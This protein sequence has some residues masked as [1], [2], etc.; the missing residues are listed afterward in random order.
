MSH[1]QMS[2]P[3][4]W[5]Q[6]DIENLEGY[7]P[8]G[9]HPTNINDKFLNGRY[10]VVHKLGY[11]SYST[12]WLAR[13]Q[14]AGRYVALKI[15]VAEVSG[16]AVES[17]ILR[18]LQ[19]GNPNHP[20]RQYIASLLNEFFFTGP[21]GHHRCLVS[22][23]HGCS[24]AESKENSTDFKFSPDISRAIAAQVTLGLAYMHS[25]G[26]GHGDL[27]ARNI[28]LRLDDIDCMSTQEIYERFGKPF[29]VS[30]RRMDKAPIGQEAPTH[31]IIPM[32]TIVPSNRVKDCRVKIT[33]FGTSFL[34]SDCKAPTT[35][36]TPTTLLPPEAFFNDPINV[37]ADIWTLGC[38]LYDI[39]GERPLFETW[40]GDPDDV[41]GEM[42]STLGPFPA[43]WWQK[44]E[45]RPVFF[46]DDGRWNPKFNRIQTPEFRSLD[47]RM[48]TMGRGKT[49]ETCEFEEAEMDSLRSLL[50]AM[51]AYEPSERVTAEGAL[52]SEYMRR[53]GRPALA[54][55]LS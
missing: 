24:V 43:R 44:W 41:L 34:T 16:K 52:E 5:P 26:V 40:A 8:G 6:D 21:N 39:L 38:T 45:N 30:I 55:C 19:S 48:W 36:H 47:Q 29:K 17:K 12:V 49:S 22:E 2:S 25:Q 10:K 31:A 53:W 35:L 20:G 42:V 18:R 11:G 32:D 3:I 54:R 33:D 14:E 37:S 1:S 9:Y 13:D 28:L 27:H 51:L 50:A 15:I 7:R 23:V 46:L 4:Y